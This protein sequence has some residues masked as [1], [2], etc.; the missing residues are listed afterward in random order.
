VTKDGTLINKAGL[1]TGGSSQSDKE[2]EKKWDRAPQS[3]K[4]LKEH[5]EL[6]KVIAS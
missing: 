3:R 4:D 6:K 2:R 1:I 5:D